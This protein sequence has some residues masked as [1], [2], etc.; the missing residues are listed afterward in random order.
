VSSLI[1]HLETN[2]KPTDV[3][4]VVR[5]PFEVYRE[6]AKNFLTSHALADFRKCPLL[7]RKRMLG[8]IADEDR[9]AYVIGEA[10]H[11]LVLEGR[12]EF[13][14]TYAVGGPINPSTGQPYGSNTKAFT[15]WAA[16]CGKQV[17]TTAQY[18][19]VQDIAE[20]VRSHQFAADLLSSGIPEG[21]VRAEY[22]NIPCQIRLDWLDPHRCIADLKTCDDVGWFQA[23]AKRYG[24]VYQVAFYR[25]V[26]KQVISLPMP[27]Y[28]IAAEK[29][30]PFRCGVWKVDE[31]VLN[32]AQ[33]ENEA[34][35]ERLKLCLAADTW[36]TGYAEMRVFDLI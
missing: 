11:K 26:L 18:Q 30:E 32:Q 20:G 15:E 35:I 14:N 34:T 4:C 29:R 23:D 10:V 3:G 2:S 19:L 28:F 12:V 31:D 24:Y 33:R 16:R 36:P 6:R 21:V 5:E 1:G 17:L 8:L 25:A 22:C 27:M 7:Y 13:D 9:P